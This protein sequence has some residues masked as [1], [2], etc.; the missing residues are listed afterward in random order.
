MSKS[1][2]GMSDRA[3]SKTRSALPRPIPVFTG[4]AIYT[5]FDKESDFDVK[6]DQFRHPGDKH[7]EKHN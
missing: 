6:N 3:V 1:R 7:M 5:A 2:L 4:G